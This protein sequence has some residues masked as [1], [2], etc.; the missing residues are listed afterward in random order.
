[1]TL[2]TKLFYSFMIILL[3]VM[4]SVWLGQVKSSQ[5]KQSV[6]EVTLKIFPA[7]DQANHLSKAI[8]DTK[9]AVLVALGGDEGYLIEFG[10]AAEDFYRSVDEILS[11]NEDAHLQKIADDY[12]DFYELG[13]KFSQNLNS[14]DN[15][16]A[17]NGL[18]EITDSKDLILYEINSYREEKRAAYQKAMAD[19]IQESKSLKFT[20]LASGVVL[21]AFLMIFYLNAMLFLKVIQSLV[22]S[23]DR[24]GKGDLTTEISTGRDDELGVLQNTFESMRMALRDMIFNLDEKVKEKT[25]EVEIEKEA[26]H[27]AKD[28]AQAGTKAKSEFLANMS[29]EIR[30]PMNGILGFSNLLYDTQLDPD[31]KESV[32]LI[33]HSA[34][35]LL[36][37]INDIL[38]FSKIEAGKMTLESIALDYQIVVNDTLNILSDQAQA[39][40]IKLSKDFPKN[41]PSC[42]L[43]DP[44]RLRQILLNLVSNAVKFTDKGDVCV[45]VTFDEITSKKYTL[46]T[47]VIDT[48]IGLTPLQ[49][50]DIFKSFNQA[51][52]ST[53]RKS[54]GTGLGTTIGKTLAELMG[55]KMTASSEAGKGS[56]FSF[57]LPV[58][59]SNIPLIDQSISGKPTR[60]YRKTI[61]LAEDNVINQKVAIKTLEKFGIKVILG[62]NGQEAVDLAFQESHALILMDIQMPVL[63]GVEAAKILFKKGYDKPIIAMTA[64][65]MVSDIEN[66]KKIGFH[67]IIPKPFDLQYLARVL[68]QYLP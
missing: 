33:I 32:Q 4:I 29:H 47:R 1:M 45:S 7:L 15:I 43:G 54:G 60:N 44:T 18:K 35:S 31:Q 13:L 22:H 24:L 2:K 23:A 68:D 27:L 62:K 52:L 11:K 65:I 46:T 41:Y 10:K 55:G 67:D 63:S 34:R 25:K 61:I 39:K 28:Q 58:E 37:I 57:E 59:I 20:F 51:D 48:G 3:T 9:N 12:S 38:D 53:T 8:Q 49:L 14:M 66:Y 50:K 42:I 16:F 6:E 40:G 5:I 30:T 21:I 64:N 36:V 19:I 56:T 26:L 17:D